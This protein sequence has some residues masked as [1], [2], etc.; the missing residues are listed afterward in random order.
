MKLKIFLAFLFVILLA[1]LGHAFILNSLGGALVVQDKL[2]KADAI[3]VLA[4]DNNGERVAQAVQLYRGKWA[5]RLLMSG[6]PAA[7]R[8]TYAENMREEAKFLGVP[9]KDIFLQDKSESTHDDAMYSLPILKKLGARTIILV[10]SPYHTRRASM[11]LRKMYRRDGI[12]IIPYP[13]QN[14]K[15]STRDWWK[16]HESTQVVVWEMLATIEYLFKGW[17]I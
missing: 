14:S 9:D 10:T 17:L 1:W 5:P 6:G 16:S 12:R 7:W 2:E 8:L 3:L 15:W 11:V 4:G 13:V